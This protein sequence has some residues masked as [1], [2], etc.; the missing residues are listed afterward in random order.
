MRYFDKLFEEVTTYI[1]S[2]Q[3]KGENITQYNFIFEMSRFNLVLQGC[4]L[5]KCF[6]INFR[7]KCETTVTLF[8]GVPVYVHFFQSYEN[9]YPASVHNTILVNGKKMIIK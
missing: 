2:S 4:P 9:N 6:K 3:E 1:R 7:T 8:P 5:C